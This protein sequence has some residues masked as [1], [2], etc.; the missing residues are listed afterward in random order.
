LQALVNFRVEPV[1][2]I[3]L[4]PMAGQLVL[5]VVKLVAVL[6]VVLPVGQTWELAE[7]GGSF[8]RAS[9]LLQNL[10]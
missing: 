9:D 8:Y 4:A 3:E 7:L 10:N 1:V 2:L 6:F 5:L